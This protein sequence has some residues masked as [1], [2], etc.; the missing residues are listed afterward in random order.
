MT[1]D[2]YFVPIPNKH[3]EW[4]CA[5]CKKVASERLKFE[6]PPRRNCVLASRGLG[7]TVAKVLSW[8]GIQECGGC[9]G[10]RQK[11]NERFPYR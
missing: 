6:T 7:D 10:R 2:C 4:I 5:R 9:G 3:G 11:L 1:V 8:F